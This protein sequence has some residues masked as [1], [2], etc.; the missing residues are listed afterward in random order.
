MILQ[1]FERSTI[2]NSND[3][4]L[5]TNKQQLVIYYDGHCPLCSLEMLKLK[6]HDKHNNI[7]LE[8]LHQKDFELQFPHISFDRAMAILHGEYNGKILLGLDV[9]HKAWQLVD[10]G[11]YV[12]PLQWP[13]IKQLSHGIY[14]IIAKY[15][16]PI[17]RF[18]NKH[19]GLGIRT[20]NPEQCKKP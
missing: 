15:R 20:C 14:L 3:N 10:K 18:L 19:L 16:Q 1:L 8:D 17:S 13:I 9:T 5:S 7:L 6:Q 4:Q 2:K 12:A 11:V